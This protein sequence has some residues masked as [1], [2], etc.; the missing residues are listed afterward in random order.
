MNEKL[1]WGILSTGRIAGTFAKALA[2]SHTGELVAVAS[3]EPA[4]AEAFAAH[5]GAAVRAY[6]SYAALLADPAVQAV[7]I[8]TPHPLHCEW[9]IRAAEAGK[10]VLVEKPAGLNHAEGM[11]MVEAA[12][13]AGV[14]FMEAFMYRHHPLT[15][16][17]VELI[18]QGSIGQVQMIEAHFAFRTGAGPESRLI[19]RELGGGGIL[20]VGCYPVSMARL[21]AGAAAGQP[22]AEPLAVQGTA[23]LGET[24]VDEYAAALLT[25]PKG[26]LASVS[27]GV[28]LN[29]DNHVAVY[30]TGGKIISRGPWFCRG[31]LELHRAGQDAPEFFRVEEPRNLYAYQI[32]AVADHL[33]DQ[34]APA[35][36]PA[37]TLGNLR[38]LDQWR[39][40]I[41]LVYPAEEKRSTWEPV[42]G[43]GLRRPFRAEIA[44]AALPGVEKPVARLI[45]GVDNQPHGAHCLVMFDDY[46]ERG[47]NC[48]DTAITYGGWGRHEGLLADY[49]HRRGVREEVVILNKGCHT[50]LNH[51]YFVR[52]HIEESLRNMRLD[53]FDVWMLH[54]DNPELPASAFV[55]ELEQARR[56]GLIRSYGGSNWSLERVRE[57]Q[58]YA[59]RTGAAGFAAVSNN[60]SLADMVSPVWGGCIASSTPEYRA[61]HAEAQLPL[62]AWSSQARGFF[63]DR[64]GPAKRD[65]AELVRCWYSEGNF[66]RRERALE[67]AARKGVSGLNVALAYVLHQPFPT[68]ALVGPR[69]LEETRTLIPGAGLA[70]T[71]EEV[72]WLEGR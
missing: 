26:V 70:L 43:R 33:A 15:R 41:K 62:M 16:K 42:P 34:A 47:G 59:A 39:A 66:A 50:P 6:G 24:G 69:T 19:S 45:M 7:Y 63:T 1:R 21:L 51:P 17:L 56:D 13:R 44:K 14:F 40:S 72:A 30:G 53:Y 8:A 54:R 57:A 35:M 64:A 55:D 61:Y 37:D 48:F 25:F 2:E 60:F 11:A 18:G 4:K 12:H 9:A 68:F 5:H 10:A 22:F 32:D 49:L 36:T 71:P 67:L 58:A 29:R 31:E 28:R 65:D 46:L 27:T 52:K 20:D 38:A 23:V 3:R